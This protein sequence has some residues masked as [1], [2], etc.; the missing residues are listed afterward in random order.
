MTLRKT[1]FMLP[2]LLL[3]CLSALIAC[4]SATTDRQAEVAER[5]AQVMPF[6]LERTTHIFEKLDDGGLQQVISDDGNA[7][8]IQLIRDHL[9]EE[10]E[11]FQNGDFHDPAMIHGDNMAGLHELVMGADRLTITYSDIDEGGQILYTASDADLINALHM[12]FDQQVSD[13]GSH[14]EGH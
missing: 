6:D 10:A 3:I 14:A 4:G 2:L 1:N 12:W 13:H 9:A 11:R 5:G 7:T 8:Q